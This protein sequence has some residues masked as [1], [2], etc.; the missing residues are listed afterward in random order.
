MNWT[1]G[2]LQR[3]KNANRGVTPKQK[4]HFARIRAQVEDTAFSNPQAF[5]SSM[6]CGDAPFSSHALHHTGHSGTPRDHDNGMG[7]SPVVRNRPKTHHEAES[8]PMH[9]Q[10]NG[11]ASEDGNSECALGF[12]PIRRTS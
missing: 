10:T 4:A 1:G 11:A 7:I 2:K 3:S 9:G 8:R 12:S 5:D 6:A